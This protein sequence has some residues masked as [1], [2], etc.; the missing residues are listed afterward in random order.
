M[1]AS[2]LL[3]LRSLLAVVSQ[4]GSGEKFFVNALKMFFVRYADLPK[5]KPYRF[6]VQTLD[7]AQTPKLKLENAIGRIAG[8]EAVNADKIP[9]PPR[10]RRGLEIPAREL[11]FHR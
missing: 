7:L 9:R 10:G 3:H 2:H 6:D 1:A 5:G 4:Q 8:R 11:V